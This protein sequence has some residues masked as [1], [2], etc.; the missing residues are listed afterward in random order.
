MVAASSAERPWAFSSRARAWTVL[1]TARLAA[2]SAPVPIAPCEGTTVC[3][4]IASNVSNAAIQARAL[5]TAV[6]ARNDSFI[7]TSPENSTLSPATKN[8]VSPRVCVGPTTTILTS[9]PPSDSTCSRS[10][11]IAAGRR[12]AS[13]S[14]SAFAGERPENIL[15]ICMPPCANSSS[16]IVEF[17]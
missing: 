7:T 9:T 2:I 6:A 16:W 12:A 13:A 8:P 17:T 1:T 10:N 14:S 3:G 15:T 11:V 4:F 5:D